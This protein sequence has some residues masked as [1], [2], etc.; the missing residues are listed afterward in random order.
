MSRADLPRLPADAR[1]RRAEDEPAPIDTARIAEDIGMAA[2][3]LAKRARAAGLTTIGYLLESVAL[4]AGTE[5]AARQWPTDA[6]A[7]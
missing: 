6:S 7:R 2:L 4:E 5:A 3:E 1:Q